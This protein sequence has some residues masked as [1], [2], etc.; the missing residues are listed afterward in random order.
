M[1][2]TRFNSSSAISR[3]SIAC[4]GTSGV[5]R[6]R[7]TVFIT[8]ASGLLI[9]WAMLA[10]MRP[11]EASFS[12]CKNRA[13]AVLRAVMSRR[14]LCT[15]T[16]PCQSM[17]AA[18]ASTATSRPS[19]RTIRSSRS[20]AMPPLLHLANAL[21]HQIVQL[22]MDHV[23]HFAALQLLPVVCAKQPQGHLIHVDDLSVQVHHHRVR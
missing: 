11:T 4:S 23:Q 16:A 7:Y 12:V 6:A 9:S 17:L 13:S 14:T 15:A 1:W 3:N 5:L 18:V 20:G 10:A 21:A 22:G 8:A 2:E 19:S